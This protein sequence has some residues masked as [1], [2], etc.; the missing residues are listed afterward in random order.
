MT[1]TPIKPAPAEIPDQPVRLYTVE[2]VAEFARASKRYVYDSIRR[3]DLPYVD[4]GNG[5]AKWRV[6]S[7]HYQDWVDQHTHSTK[8]AA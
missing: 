5:R 2:E 7:D 6:R 1:V 4:L 8:G 3:G